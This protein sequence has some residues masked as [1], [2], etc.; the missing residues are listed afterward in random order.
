MFQA[1]PN[2]VSILHSKQFMFLIG[3]N[4]EPI[5]IHAGA[6]GALS[7]PLER[8][9][10]GPMKEAQDNIARF[11][12]LEVIDFDRICEFACRGNY[13]DPD[14]AILDE[15]DVS[16]DTEDRALS[17]SIEH[18]ASGF[19]AK[20]LI[21][22]FSVKTYSGPCS[23]STSIRRNFR[24]AYKHEK[25]D[26]NSPWSSFVTPFKLDQWKHDMRPSSSVTRGYTS[27]HRCT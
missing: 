25:L 23:A 17:C 10:N 3:P 5:T 15:G 19:P 13:T 8:L 4:E 24:N 11:P 21:T 7:S 6:I 27:S 12:T 14:V 16:E 22:G 9:V 26:L 18:A 2:I 1:L 20:A